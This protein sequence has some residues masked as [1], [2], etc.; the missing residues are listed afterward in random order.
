MALGTLPPETGMK[1]GGVE[2]PPP[3]TALQKKYV[4][5]SLLPPGDSSL[6]EEEGGGGGGCPFPPEPS[7]EPYDPFHPPPPTHTRMKEVGWGK[8]TA[9]EHRGQG[10]IRGGPGGRHAHQRTPKV[11]G[12]SFGP[13]I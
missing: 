9:L 12:E 10:G 11:V 6:R 2:L 5:K 13:I 8:H 1:G 7:P 4:Q 3:P